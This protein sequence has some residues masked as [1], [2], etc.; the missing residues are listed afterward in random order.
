MSLT[1]ILNSD[2]LLTK[3]QRHYAL[4][5]EERRAA[6]HKYYHEKCKFVL[7]ERRHIERERK[8]QDKL[9]ITQSQSLVLTPSGAPVLS[10]STLAFSPS[11]AA[12]S[13]LPASTPPPFDDSDDE[14]G[15]A[16]VLRN[17]ER[18]QKTIANWERHWGG[19]RIW[20][21]V[22]EQ[23]LVSSPSKLSPSLDKQLRFEYDSQVSEGQEL[24]GQI[25]ELAE[26]C[27]QTLMNS[28]TGAAHILA[29]NAYCIGD[30]LGRLRVDY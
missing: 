24:L 5:A 18:L 9:A 29:W 3:H 16:L 7:Q 26:R 19:R 10:C 6:A 1:N 12:S 17:V 4:H 8:L 25:W 15:S 21:L 20:N 28:L 2:M 14:D 13:P 23:V 22:A 11:P 27:D 30:G